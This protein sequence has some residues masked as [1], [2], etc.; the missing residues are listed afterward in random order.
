MNYKALFTDL[1]GVIRIWR[2]QNEVDTMPQSGLPDGAIRQ[3]AF[4][5]ELVQ[6]AIHGQCTH[7]EWMRQVEEQLQREYPEADAKQIMQ[8]FSE[9]A[10][11][12]DHRVL[13]LIRA[14]RKTAPVYLITNATSRLPSDLAALGLNEEF[15][16]V[17]NSSDIGYA[18]P[19][20]EIFQT[21]LQ[22]AGVTAEQS[23]F[24]DDTEKNV[25]AAADLGFGSHL[26]E[27]QS[28]LSAHLMKIG[29]LNLIY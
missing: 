29:L 17:I 10:G 24:V 11:E 22:I 16:Q 23:F 14:C 21:A 8:R 7:E 2:R 5:P 25:L 6:P 18:K 1:D 3:I 28:K 13:G 20:P 26:Y 9:P 15:D 27:S 4:S 12:V 19:G